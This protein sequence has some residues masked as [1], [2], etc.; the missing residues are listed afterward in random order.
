[1]DCHRELALTVCVLFCG[2]VSTQGESRTARPSQAAVRA[3]ATTPSSS[4]NERM[5]EQ[6]ST[7]LLRDDYKEAAAIV[8]R[9]Q[10]AHPPEQPGARLIAY[11]D[12]TVHSY[13]GDYQ[14]AAAVMFDHIANVGPTTVDAFNFHDAMIALRTAD[15]DLIGALVEC[16]EMVKAGAAGSWGTSEADRMTS[17]R[18]KEHWHRAYLLRMIAQTLTGAEG[19]ALIGYAESA[20]QEYISL[21]TPIGNLG[22]SIAALD[23]YF[24]YCDG[25]SAKMRAAAQRLNVAQND[26]VEDLYLAQLAFDGAGDK[27]AA[28]AVRRRIVE[29]KSVTVLVPV[30]LAWMRAD[31]ETKEGRRR[32]SPKHPTGVRPAH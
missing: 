18:L 17:V 5:F 6:V 30:F 1:M 14:G 20:R 7:A 2:C 19:L 13:Q 4:A 31:E 28:A 3:P 16:E 12:A 26:D 32:F 29:L 27:E 10:R 11:L 24:A 15:G 8:E 21:A 23:A 22:D 9:A 25:S